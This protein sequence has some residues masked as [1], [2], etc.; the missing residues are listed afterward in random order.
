VTTRVPVGSRQWLLKRFGY[1]ILVQM[2]VEY[3]S[4]EFGDM[5]DWS[6]LAQN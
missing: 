4:L 6:V 1:H 2:L 5:D 3:R